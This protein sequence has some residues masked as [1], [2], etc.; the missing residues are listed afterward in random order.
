MPH[1]GAER[2]IG[3][4]VTEFDQRRNVLISWREGMHGQFAEPAA[5]VDLVLRA[6]ILIA[7]ASSAARRLPEMSPLRKPRNSMLALGLAAYDL[8]TGQRVDFRTI[9]VT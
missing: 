9:Q 8:K 4:V 5:E 1:V 7:R 3:L 6:D 2:W